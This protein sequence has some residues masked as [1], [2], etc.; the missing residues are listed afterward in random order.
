MPPLPS[1]QPFEDTKNFLLAVRGEILTSQTYRDASVNKKREYLNRFFDDIAAPRLAQF[2]LNAEDLEAVRQDLLAN[3]GPQDVQASIPSFVPPTMASA[4]Q[5][6]AN[7]QTPAEIERRRLDAQFQELAGGEAT[8]TPRLSAM[9]MPGGR[10]A[11]TPEKDLRLIESEPLYRPNPYITNP[12]EDLSSIQDPAMRTRFARVNLIYNSRNGTYPREIEKLVAGQNPLTPEGRETIWRLWEMAHTQPDPATQQAMGDG[13]EQLPTT[14][15]QERIL[16][17]LRTP[18]TMAGARPIM[19]VDM[20]AYLESISPGDQVMVIPDGVR[21]YALRLTQDRRLPQKPEDTPTVG[22]MSTM[23]K[24]DFYKRMVDMFARQVPGAMQELLR[25]GYNRPLRIGEA[26]PDDPT[27]AIRE[28]NPELWQAIGGWYADNVLGRQETLALPEH[29]K[30]LTQLQAAGSDILA[31]Y[32]RE[33]DSIG[34]TAEDQAREEALA[35]SG[36]MQRVLGGA[37]SAFGWDTEG[38]SIVLSP[39]RGALNSINNIVRGGAV[40]YNNLEDI[41]TGDSTPL[42]QET[43]ALGAVARGTKL[44]ADG[45]RFLM[46]RT[47]EPGS[48][49]DWASTIGE[50]GG[51]LATQI[52]G[53]FLLGPAALGSSAAGVAAG[54]LLGTLEGGA[55]AYD[56]AI[57]QGGTEEQA[58]AA[59]WFGFGGGLLDFIPVGRL[60]GVIRREAPEVVTSQGLR[61]LFTR[62]LAPTTRARFVQGV[63]HAT[64]QGLSEGATE[65]AQELLN[66]L[67]IQQFVDATQELFTEDMLKEGFIGFLLG[68]ALGSAYQRR[69]LPL[70][71]LAADAVRQG[72]GPIEY[73]MMLDKAISH[74][75]SVAREHNIVP[76][77][78]AYENLT[79]NARELIVKQLGPDMVT[80]RNVAAV[81]SRIADLIGEV[82]PTQA[83]DPRATAGLVAQAVSEVGRNAMAEPIQRQIANIRAVASKAE[84]DAFDQMETAVANTLY[85]QGAPEARLQRLRQDFGA[86]SSQAVYRASV[87]EAFNTMDPRKGNEY[88]EQRARFNADIAR[89]NGELDAILNPQ[90]PPAPGGDGEAPIPIPTPTETE[91]APRQAASTPTPI[92]DIGASIRQQGQEGAPLALTPE[93]RGALGGDVQTIASALRTTPHLSAMTQEGLTGLAEELAKEGTGLQDPA[94]TVAAREAKLQQMVEEANKA[95]ATP[96]PEPAPT[97][98]PGQPVPPQPG[99]PGTPADVADVAAVPA[100]VAGATAPETQP[101]AAPEGAE[102]APLG[103][104]AEAPPTPGA[105]EPPAQPA[106]TAPA[107]KPEGGARPPRAKPRKPVRDAAQAKEQTVAETEAQTSITLDAVRAPVQATAIDQGALFEF[108]DSLDKT[109]TKM[110]KDAASAYKKAKGGIDGIASAAAKLQ[111]DEAMLRQFLTKAIPMGGSGHSPGSNPSESTLYASVLGLASA[112]KSDVAKARLED[113]ASELRPSFSPYAAGEANALMRAE[114]ADALAMWAENPDASVITGATSDTAQAI[115]KSIV[116]AATGQ[117]V[118][119]TRGATPKGKLPYREAVDSLESLLRVMSKLDPREARQ[120]SWDT[121]SQRLAAIHTPAGQAFITALRNIG[122]LDAYMAAMQADIESSIDDIRE[123]PLRMNEAFGSAAANV[124]S[125]RVYPEPPAEVEVAQPTYAQEAP[126]ESAAIASAIVDGKKVEAAVN[127]DTGAIVGDQPKPGETD[128]ETRARNEKINALISGL[129]P[130]A[131]GAGATPISNVGKPGAKTPHD[132]YAG[133]PPLYTEV[134]GAKGQGASGAKPMFP[135][136]QEATPPGTKIYPP[137]EVASALANGFEALSARMQGARNVSIPDLKIVAGTTMRRGLGVYRTPTGVVEISA[138][139]TRPSNSPLA[140]IAHEIGHWLM[141]IKDKATNRPIFETTDPRVLAELEWLATWHPASDLDIQQARDIIKEQI[142]SIAG[143]PALAGEAAAMLQKRYAQNEGFANFILLMA[144]NPT[145]AQY[146]QGRGPMQSALYEHV[147]GRL[148]ELDA[149]TNKAFGGEILALLEAAAEK[150]RQFNGA[151]ASRRIAARGQKVEKSGSLMAQAAEV[152]AAAISGDAKAFGRNASTFAKKA[153][154]RFNFEFISQEG[155]FI[156]RVNEAVRQARRAASIKGNGKRVRLETIAVRKGSDRMIEANIVNGIVDPITKQP[157]KS[158]RTGQLINL[159]YMLAPIAGPDVATLESEMQALGIS[160]QVPHY[161]GNILNKAC[162]EAKATA[163]KVLGPG[164]TYASIHNFVANDPVL[165]ALDKTSAASLAADILATDPGKRVE[166][167][168]KI[169]D[170]VATYSPMAGF[171]DYAE[172]DEDGYPKWNPNAYSGHTFAGRIARNLMDPHSEKFLLRNADGSYRQMTGLAP[173]VR[174]NEVLEAAKIEREYRQDRAAAIAALGGRRVIDL[175][176]GFEVVMKNGVPEIESVARNGKVIGP[177]SPGYA[178]AVAKLVDSIPELRKSLTVVEAL[179]RHKEAANA[180]L[181]VIY[182]GGLIS[183][184]KYIE[185]LGNKEYLPM[186]RGSEDLAS[187]E[188]RVP[189]AER[190]AMSPAVVFLEHL[191]A[192]VFGDGAPYRAGTNVRADTDPAKNV[193]STMRREGTFN[194]QVKPFTDN[195]VESLRDALE[196]ITLNNIYKELVSIQEELDRET[197]GHYDLGIVPVAKGSRAPDRSFVVIKRGERSEYQFSEGMWPQE[198][199]DTFNMAV[200]KAMAGQGA[201]AK[202]LAPIRYLSRL[203][204]ALITQVPFFSFKFLLNNP[205]TDALTQPFYSDAYGYLGFLNKHYWGDRGISA[206]SLRAFAEGMLADPVATLV[207]RNAKLEE[208]I[209]RIQYAGGGQFGLAGNRKEIDKMLKRMR[210]ERPGKA[211]FFTVKKLRDL[212]AAWDAWAERQEGRTRVAE[213]RAKYRKAINEGKSHEE[214]EQTAAIAARELMDFTRAGRTIQT[215]NQYIPFLNAAVQGWAKDIRTITAAEAEPEAKVKAILNRIFALGTQSFLLA[216]LGAGLMDDEDERRWAQ[217]PEY[218]RN[219]FICIGYDD[220]GHPFLVPKPFGLFGAMVNV[221]EDVLLNRH[222]NKSRVFE[223]LLSNITPLGIVEA[224]SAMGVPTLAGVETIMEVATNKNTFTRQPIT[225]VPE[226]LSPREAQDLG[227]SGTA[228]TFGRFISGAVNAPWLQAEDVDHIVKSLFPRAGEAALKTVDAVA[229]NRPG[230]LFAVAERQIPFHGQRLPFMNSAAATEVREIL[231]ARKV[232]KSQ[233]TREWR[234]AF[235]RRLSRIQHQFDELRGDAYKKQK[236]LE[237]NPQALNEYNQ[238]VQ[239]KV[240]KWRARLREMEERY[241]QLTGGDD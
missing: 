26:P 177:T 180:I 148:K 109:Q 235:G 85:P 127:V 140:I 179:E 147:V 89:L 198:M 151:D 192:P 116:K 59:S 98:E 210:G 128:E 178:K 149:A 56:R 171:G 65:M 67:G 121:V 231:A 84:Q 134:Y 132:A 99:A 142:P 1:T 66:N 28:N 16:N 53:A 228:S 234:M 186:F 206:E 20:A 50:A 70:E 25:A 82:G 100:D 77:E 73:V 24:A 69:N 79:R 193:E 3:Y 44:F 230:G 135:I 215:L 11:L 157:I 111:A 195:I 156:S 197:G 105:G 154:D 83:G 239:A 152:A 35:T 143:D 39:L 145:F 106:P 200:G 21:P 113:I 13:Q 226:G 138:R 112:A 96:T 115:A 2:G 131:Q 124:Q 64:V 219:R 23:S 76:G 176:G 241:Q 232:P 117:D 14:T 8:S 172:A 30:P 51:Q 91:T 108:G 141:E 54:A 221:W 78:S 224:N 61:E 207:N 40:L 236:A 211:T 7:E 88:A 103:E 150:V 104:A 188:S 196:A 190:G 55:S 162:Q 42:D 170:T 209:L 10:Y 205:I 189:E 58:Q 22:R 125:A 181:E 68:G 137:T 74:L 87:V 238:E 227:F 49:Q 133:D 19:G 90:P 174:V 31:P 46:P 218:V 75:E 102:P 229:S 71:R 86:G 118:G 168:N 233:W 169:L 213:F 144:T 214:A 29:R 222:G 202:W 237:D 164:A 194:R 166:A 27:Q 72:V 175:G 5:E 203:Q 158:R 101:P 43:G 167:V 184:G 146:Y 38:A 60:F 81:A 160:R 139:A 126:A 47:A 163:T 94:A 9:P 217:E 204:R 114:I 4:I 153:L 122:K 191:E 107:P 63:R 201:I 187:F 120:P 6:V 12:N 41:I 33:P 48:W 161:F 220:E 57:A 18:V 15:E 240:A 185:W 123:T 165:G 36:V 97:M 182:R 92:D 110:A 199:V 34:L 80:D 225:F 155:P 173:D 216:S 93:Q 119:G 208:D 52:G 159:R 129:D 62:Y 136:Q 130:L 17:S 45:L 212:R 183:Y 95:L 37:A 32:V 223:Q